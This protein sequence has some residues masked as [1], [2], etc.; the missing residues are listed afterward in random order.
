MVIAILELKERNIF[1][2][3]IYAWVGF[4]AMTLDY[5]RPKRNEGETKFSFSRLVRIG[6]DGLVSF[7]SFPL[8]I[9]SALG[10][11]LGFLAI[12]WTLTIIALKVFNQIEMPGY[13]SLISI[14]LFSTA[15]NLF[16][17]GIFGEYISR[18][19]IETKNRPHYVIERTY[20]FEES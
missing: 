10:V 12:L 15:I 19:F 17:F 2:K 20:G 8:R 7:S 16:C 3:G 4:E 18:L 11:L 13:A 1:M 14:S 5:V 9:W 6:L